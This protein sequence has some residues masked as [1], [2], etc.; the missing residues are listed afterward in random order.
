[1]NIM[2]QV[3]DAEILMRSV[4]ADITNEVKVNNENSSSKNIHIDDGGCEKP[5]DEALNNI[6]LLPLSFKT[7][8]ISLEE[9]M[10]PKDPGGKLEEDDKPE[11]IQIDSK[12]C[13]HIMEE[14]GVSVSAVV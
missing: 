14:V 12:P 5:C 4:T 6:E 13:A 11:D 8:K 7:E 1:M 2:E 3:H 10:A 9:N